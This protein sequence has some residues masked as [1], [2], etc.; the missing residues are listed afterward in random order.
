GDGVIPPHGGSR[1]GYHF[2]ISIA[3][4]A[5]ESW[6]GHPQS[7]GGGGGGGVGRA[8]GGGRVYFRGPRGTRAALLTPRCL[9]VYLW[10]AVWPGGRASRG[11]RETGSVRCRFAAVSDTLGRP[12]LSTRPRPHPP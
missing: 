7:P 12:W 10:G 1:G 2:A 3:S 6:R 5:V 4:E 8:G 11:A 9:S